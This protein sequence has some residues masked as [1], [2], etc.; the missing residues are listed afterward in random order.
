MLLHSITCIYNMDTLLA[1]VVY[2]HY[3]HGMFWH[4]RSSNSGEGLGYLGSE[5]FFRHISLDLYSDSGSI[6]CSSTLLLF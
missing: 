4:S 2:M 6:L 1:C 3:T 5:T